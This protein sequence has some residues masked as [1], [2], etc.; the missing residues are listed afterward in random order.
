[1]QPSHQEAQRQSYFDR[2]ATSC[3]GQ[4]AS[5]TTLFFRVGP[6]SRPYVVRDASTEQCL[7]A[8][9]VGF[10][11]RLVV[12]TAALLL[13][14]PL[15]P[16]FWAALVYWF[17]TKTSPLLVGLP[18]HDARLTLSSALRTRA[19]AYPA[20]LLACATVFFALLTL[21]GAV[22]FKATSN[23]DLRFALALALII[24]ATAAGAS[25]VMWRFRVRR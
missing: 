22:A 21:A 20:V 5:G 3:F 4:D 12:G 23:E 13:V 19:M 9:S 1:M 18:R 7:R 25:A 11:R 15:L 6:L 2:L 14:F 16:I 17:S 24:S 8:V 10:Y